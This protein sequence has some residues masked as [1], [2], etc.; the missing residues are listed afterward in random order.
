LLKVFEFDS[1]RKMMSVV[2]KNNKNQKLYL[3]TKGADTS[4]LPLSKNDTKIQ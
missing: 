4:I 3:F 2:V 1:E